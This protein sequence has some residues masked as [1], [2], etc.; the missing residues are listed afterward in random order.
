MLPSYGSDK[1]ES[2][3]MLSI[4]RNSNIISPRHRCL[5]RIKILSNVTDFIERSVAHTIQMSQ[6]LESGDE[7]VENL[8]KTL[9][10]IAVPSVLLVDSICLYTSTSLHICN[11]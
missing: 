11:F 9:S 7:E 5:V 2:A 4:N 3:D 6:D 10:M 8:F 1:P